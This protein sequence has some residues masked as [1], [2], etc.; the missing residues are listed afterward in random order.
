M[1]KPQLATVR[2]V[3]RP[4]DAGDLDESYALWTDPDVRRYLW[5]DVVID[6]DRAVDVVAASNDHFDRYGYGLW[7][8]R[9]PQSDELIGV[10]GFRPS[11]A[12][13]PELLFALW[14]K[15]WTRGFAQE[16]ARTVI[17]YVFEVLGRAE[18]VAATDV[19]N[20]ASARALQRLG[21]Q[22]ERRGTLNGLDTYFYRL[23]RDQFET[24]P[25]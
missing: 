13:E 24:P 14:P 17:A 3:L 4:L 6:H 7:T 18:V 11:E 12:A 19:P 2:T 20:E 25:A 16:A 1:N 8:I 5:D 10:C 21:M 22:L 9:D 15:F 23:T